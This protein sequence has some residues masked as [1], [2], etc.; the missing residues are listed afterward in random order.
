MDY[1][2][3]LGTG[4]R[5]VHPHDPGVHLGGIHALR[6]L[7]DGVDA[8][9][10]LCRI[11]ADAAPAPGVAPGDHVEVW[12]V[13]TDDPA[14]NPNLDYVLHQAATTLAALRTEGRAVLVHCVAAQSRTPTL[15]A[16]HATALGI[17]PTQALAEITAALPDAHPNRAFR[18]AVQRLARGVR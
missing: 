3:Y 12:L 14:G 1:A 7:P 10:S 5:A 18:D 4:A 8:V 13:D 11:G 16:L 9:V 15:A 17:P 2:G 6:D